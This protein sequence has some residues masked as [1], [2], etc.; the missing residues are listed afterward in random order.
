MIASQ[1]LCLLSNV[2]A[3]TFHFLGIIELSNSNSQFGVISLM[4]KSREINKK[5][6]KCQS[7]Q[8]A[9]HTV[10]EQIVRLQSLHHLTFAFVIMEMQLY[11]FPSLSGF[12]IV[13]AR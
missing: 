5:R 13:G 10:S 1:A 2:P 4:E 12:G 9:A 6:A 8:K 3:H 11:W 7:I